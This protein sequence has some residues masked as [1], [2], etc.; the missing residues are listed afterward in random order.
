MIERYL[1]DVVTATIAF[2]M[3]LCSAIKPRGKTPIGD[4]TMHVEPPA[5]AAL[6]SF[7]T[8][9]HNSCLLLF[10]T[11]PLRYYCTY[12]ISPFSFI[13]GLE[14]T[15]CWS[16][17]SFLDL[18]DLEALTRASQALA[19]LTSDPV[20][21]QQR[22]QIVSPSRVNHGL[23]RTSPEGH[24]LRPTVGDLVH[25]GVIQ[26]LGI[27]RRWR[28]GSYLYT[29][30]VSCEDFSAGRVTTA[31]PALCSLSSS[32]STERLSLGDT[33]ATFSLFSSRGACKMRLAQRAPWSPCSPRTSFHTASTR[34]RS[35]PGRCCRRCIV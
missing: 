34:L 6:N 27:E 19:A 31:H 12:V 22:L 33:R 21:H 16:Q 20:L 28:M 35:L 1:V 15:K 7:T 10:S 11:L 29:L 3:A 8:D 17:V 24:A 14:L 4:L 9:Y 23:F 13:Q 25:R 2:R 18:P 30:T 5:L 32:T 26:G